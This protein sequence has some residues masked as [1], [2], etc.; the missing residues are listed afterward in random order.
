MEQSRKSRKL[1]NAI[2]RIMIV[3]TMMK[4]GYKIKGGLQPEFCGK[5]LELLDETLN[6]LKEVGTGQEE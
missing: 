5:G 3:R 1:E 2:F 6:L 4:I